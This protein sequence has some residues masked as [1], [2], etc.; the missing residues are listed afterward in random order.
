MLPKLQMWLEKRGSTQQSC[1]PTTS[2]KSA[3]FIPKGASPRTPFSLSAKWA[4]SNMVLSKQVPILVEVASIR[5]VLIP[6]EMWQQIFKWIH[7]RRVL[8]FRRLCR[9]IN[10]CLVD[11][12]FA[13]LNL[14]TYMNWQS[15]A[16]VRSYSRTHFNEFDMLWLRW[17]KPFQAVYAYQ[18][19]VLRTEAMFLS[20]SRCG[21]RIP[22]DI[23]TLNLLVFLALDNC[24]LVGAI[25]VEIGYLRCLAH[26]NL[27]KNQLSGKLP[28]SLC[29]C[30]PLQRLYLHDNLLSGTIPPEL[31]ALSQLLYVY[32]DNNRFQGALPVELTAWRNIRAF[33]VAGNRMSKMLDSR[34][35]QNVILCNLLNA[36]GFR[37]TVMRFSI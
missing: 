1:H 16:V 15:L 9:G 27:S 31:G 12:H 29:N 37:L 20:D 36:Q 10:E 35:A 14:A 8:K 3:P 13:T 23:G 18:L 6:H 5:H 22:A 19:A 4:L 34:F 7:P 26:L 33:D 21:G 11:R 30:A 17:P 25:P 2:P 28:T 24:H 32:C